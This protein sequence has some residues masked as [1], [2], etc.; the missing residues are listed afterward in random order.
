M[1]KDPIDILAER[2]ARLEAEGHIS[3]S[4]RQKATDKLNT[5]KGKRPAKPDTPKPPKP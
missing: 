4:Q 1:T 2:L 5:A 3:A